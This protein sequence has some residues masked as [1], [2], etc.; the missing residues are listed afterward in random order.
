[1]NPAVTLPHAP[2]NAWPRLGAEEEAA[3]VRI[4]RDGNISTH[5]VIRELEHD[6]A[7]F[8]GRRFALAHNNG[9]AALTAPP[10]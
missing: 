4:L 1:M 8:S 2:S 5:P 7:A 9:T 10:H 6:Y 3:V